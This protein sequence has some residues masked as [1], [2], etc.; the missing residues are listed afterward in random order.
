MRGTVCSYFYFL[1]EYI[2]GS[3]SKTLDYSFCN[4]ESD[5]YRSDKQKNSYQLFEEIFIYLFIFKKW[6]FPSCLS[7][8]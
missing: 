6:V 4:M 7:M 5:S 1:E 2:L 3:H 8:L